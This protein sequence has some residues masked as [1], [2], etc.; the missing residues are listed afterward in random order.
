LHIIGS[1]AVP[2]HGC[3]NIPLGLELYTERRFVA[4]TGMQCSG[5]V[6]ADLTP[7]IAEIAGR[8]FPPGRKRA[9]NAPDEWTSEPVAA[10]SGPTDD[11][12]LIRHAREERLVPGTGGIDLPAIWATLP[13]HLPVSIELPNE[14]L[15]RAA[16]TGP[17]LDRLAAATRDVL[18]AVPSACH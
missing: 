13:E 16:G 18:A 8:L 1:G 12:E 7:A 15:R 14:A 4:L 2:E 11:A 5:S 9:H 6:R 3:R 10:W 17:W